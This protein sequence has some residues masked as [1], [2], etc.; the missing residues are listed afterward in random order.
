MTVTG[1]PTEVGD[2]GGYAVRATDGGIGTVDRSNAA[3]GGA[4]LV[5]A[6]RRW[7]LARIVLLPAAV[8]DRIDHDHQVV[9]V[10]CTKSEVSG[11]PRHR[12]DESR[13]VDLHDYYTSIRL[14]PLGGKV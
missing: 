13:R 3:T 14:G 1:N 11:A 2:L 6:T 10:T 7:I 12:D 5:V 8:I 4:Y 9:H